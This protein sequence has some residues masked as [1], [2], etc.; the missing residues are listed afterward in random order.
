MLT[1]NLLT[2][3]AV[4]AFVA[5]IVL[6]AI[7]FADGT[8]D[9]HGECPIA[10]KVTALVDGWKGAIEEVKAISPA[11]QQRFRTRM[12][13]LSEKCPVG[14]RLGDTLVAVRDVLGAVIADE[15][16]NAKHCPL[17]KTGEKTIASPEACAE[18]KELHG[19]RSYTLRHLH[20][21][22]G[23]VAAF[24]S[25]SC[26]A[27]TKDTTSAAVAAPKSEA[28]GAGSSP[29]STCPIR[30][31]SRLGSLKASWD[32]ARGEAAS[33]SEERRKE[34]LT[35]LESLGPPAKAVSLV[36][37]SVMAL[38]EGFDGLDSIHRKMNDWGK[39]NPE[40]LRELP[41]DALRSFH[42][43]SALIDEARDVLA[44]M[45]EAMKAMHGECASDDT[46]TDRAKKS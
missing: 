2:T 29:A 26:C 46:T 12:A 44:R 7:V 41:E 10:R 34:I 4:P 15:E 1:R 3:L 13:S 45:K 37:P 5:P 36:L 23:Y 33:L 24:T 27:E 20:S 35:G 21:L 14:S 18:A 25:G 11:E 17:Q 30:I 9:K 31:A 28:C 42:R 22:A 6:G 32:I 38:A 39:S 43:Q 19:A 8:A 16:A 40:F